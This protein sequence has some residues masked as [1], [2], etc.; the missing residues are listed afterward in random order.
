V[1]REFENYTHLT[2]AA[3][4]GGVTLISEED[5]YYTDNP[6]NG[7]LF[8]DLGKI[9]LIDATNVNSMEIEA[10][11]GCLAFKG[12]F[13]PPSNSVRALPH[14][15]TEV[16]SNLEKTGLQL[17]IDPTL[18]D[19]RMLYMAS[20]MRMETLESR[21]DA[22]TSGNLNVFAGAFSNAIESEGEEEDEDY[23][24]ESPQE[25]IKRMSFDEEHIKIHSS[26]RTKDRS[27]SG[28]GFNYELTFQRNLSHL[29]CPEITEVEEELT[30]AKKSKRK[31]N[32][33][34]KSIVYTIFDDLDRRIR[35]SQ[36][37]IENLSL[38]EQFTYHESG[39]TQFL[40]KRKKSLSL[41]P[42]DSYQSD[43]DSSDAGTVKVAPK[44]ALYERRM[45][46]RRPNPI[47]IEKKSSEND[48]KERLYIYHLANFPDH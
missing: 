16:Y 32:H 18:P 10:S 38:A 4:A 45:V 27:H 24:E 37:S 9:A 35:E 39:P 44:S 29:V 34:S 22:K 25:D 12:Y 47:K 31:K 13:Y 6:P 41:G 46:N 26:P 19:P 7:E 36:Q 23:S 43:S 17:F 48:N 30:P 2:K 14:N 33:K 3:V 1:R 15:M 11:K 40:T 21:N 42:T 28:E 5:G 8:C 20:P